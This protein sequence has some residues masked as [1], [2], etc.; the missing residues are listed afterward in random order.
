MQSKEGLECYT[1]YNTS[2][3]HKDTWQDQSTW[4]ES[5]VIMEKGR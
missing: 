1:M 3:H 2:T 4:F 5:V